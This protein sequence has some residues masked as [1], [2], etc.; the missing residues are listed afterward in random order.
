M[1]GG[2]KMDSKKLELYR[3]KVKRADAISSEIYNNTRVIDEID[4]KTSVIAG[5]GENT[6]VTFIGYRIP[7]ASALKVLEAVK[8][9]LND[10]IEDL[11]REYQ[12]L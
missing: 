8:S 3:A 5:N 10:R 9:V 12:E 1:L 6:A 2:M 4:I 7:E 11:K